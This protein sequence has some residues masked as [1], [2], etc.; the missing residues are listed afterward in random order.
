MELKNKMIL[1]NTNSVTL[2]VFGKPNTGKHTFI[3]LMCKNA[4]KHQDIVGE[5]FLLNLTPEI[6]LIDAPIQLKD[7]T[8]FPLFFVPK[9]SVSE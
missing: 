4:G 3:S 5:L 7:D 2:V 8:K 9:I 6:K 1:K